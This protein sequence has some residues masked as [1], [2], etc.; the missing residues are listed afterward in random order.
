MTEGRR[1]QFNKDKWLPVARDMPFPISHYCCQIMKKLP[2]KS[3]H[4]KEKLAPFIGTLAVESQV[5]RQAWLRHGCNAFDSRSPTSQPLSFWTEQD[6][7]EYISVYHLPICSVYGEIVP[8]ENQI[9]LDDDH[10]KLRCTG[11][12]R[13]GCVFCG[14]GA[15]LDRDR[16]T[17]LKETHPQLYRYCIEGGMWA[18]NPAYDPDAPEYDGEWK[19]WNPQKI[20]VPSLKGLGM[21]RVFEMLNEQYS[22][23][24]KEFIKYK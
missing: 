15:H 6:I 19:N 9:S 18:D 20:W 23:N 10:P 14:F 21:G 4:S 3:F 13:T 2:M 8:E 17:R 5:R 11:C 16:F 7:L 22:K 24:G 12:Q 1:S